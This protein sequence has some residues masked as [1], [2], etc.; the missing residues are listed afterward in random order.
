MQGNCPICKRGKGMVCDQCFSEFK[1]N[2]AQVKLKYVDQVI[3]PFTYDGILKD[4]M[5]EF[6]F[7]KNYAW[8]KILGQILYRA[9]AEEDFDF[10]SYDLVTFIPSD[11]IRMAKRGFNQAELMAKSFAECAG[12]DCRA[13]MRRAKIQ[14]ESHKATGKIRENIDHKFKA[15]ESGLKGAKR[16]I[17]IDDIIT[18]GRT[19]SEAGK[20]IKLATD[21]EVVAL[22][23]LGDYK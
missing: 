4:I 1:R 6:K 2:D 15:K 22:A 9:L 18:T 7:G 3:A 11:F 13:T 17:I 14:K 19:I 5:L 21:A 8:G 20:C 23:L 12:L 16:V 10:K